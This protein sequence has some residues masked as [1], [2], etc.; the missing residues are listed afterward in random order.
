MKYQKLLLGSI[1][2]WRIAKKQLLQLLKISVADKMRLVIVWYKKSYQK[3]S[4]IAW[5]QKEE[6][7]PFLDKRGIEYDSSAGQN[8]EMGGNSMT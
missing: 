1:L 4:D 5:S 7:G 3:C 2:E 8:L 6:F